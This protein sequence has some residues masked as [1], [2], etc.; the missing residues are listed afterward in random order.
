M[1][2]LQTFPAVLSSIAKADSVVAYCVLACKAICF[3]LLHDA[4]CGSAATGWSR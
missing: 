1:V 3:P 4:S 2:F